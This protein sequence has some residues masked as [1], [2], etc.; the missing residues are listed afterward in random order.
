MA[1]KEMEEITENAIKRGGIL[2]KLY[3][4][5]HSEKEDDLQ[6][7]MADMINNKLLKSPGV[8][9]CYGS[10]DEPIKIDNI[11][12]TNAVVTTLF[13][14]LGA[15]IGVAFN[16]IPAGV[17]IIKPEKE[18]VLKSSELQSIILDIA[19]ISIGYMQ[20][21]ISRSLT[22]EDLEKVQADLKA[23]EE[24]GKKLLGKSDKPS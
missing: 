4:D 22:K 18:L 2:A 8:I 17:E 3:F 24:L 20:Y 12:S 16:F 11:Y 15:L 14:D 7:L 19:Q 23:R 10:I 1:K 5:M 6:P 21:I 13:K 9:Y